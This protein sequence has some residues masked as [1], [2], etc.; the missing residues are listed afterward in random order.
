MYLAYDRVGAVSIFYFMQLISVG[1]SPISPYIS[2]Y[3][4]MSPHF[5]YFI[6]SSSR[7]ARGP[8]PTPNPNPIPNPNPTL[9]PTPTPT[10]TLPLT[11]TLSRWGRG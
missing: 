8:N 1:T 11:L 3:L 5:F 6:C 10:P 9:T 4:P 7:W 2:V